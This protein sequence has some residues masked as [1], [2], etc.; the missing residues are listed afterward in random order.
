MFSH[1]GDS[2]TVCKAE[3]VLPAPAG[4]PLAPG[5]YELM[6]DV[7]LFHLCRDLGIQLCTRFPLLCLTSSTHHRGQLFIG[8]SESY[9]VTDRAGAACA[10]R[11]AVV[12]VSI[13]GAHLPTFVPLAEE[14]EGLC[15]STAA[16]A[17]SHCCPCC[18]LSKED[19]KWHLLWP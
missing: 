15:H 17:Q 11:Q 7:V 1:A 10:S 18:T 16:A 6:R 13:F 3:D 2:R 14:I 8:S 9:S 4:C 19:K 5:V 12:Y